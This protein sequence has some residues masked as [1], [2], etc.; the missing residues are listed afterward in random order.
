MA[1]SSFV[2]IVLLCSLIIPTKCYGHYSERS[3]DVA[4]SLFIFGDSFFD[5]GNNNY[6]NTSGQ[7]NYYPYGETFFNYPSGRFCDG[8]ILP[9]FIAEYA[10]LPFI[11]P[12][13]FPGNHDFKYGANFASGGAGA[14]NE[15]R[16]GFVINLKTQLGYLKKI[17]N[18]L[19]QQMGYT[20][21]K[22]LFSKAVYIFSV[23][24]NDYSYPFD[25]NPAVL[26]SHTTQQ[27]VGMVIGNITEV[28]QEIYNIGGRKVGF[29]SLGPI[30]CAPFARVLNK[31]GACFEKFT[32]FLKLHNKQ[33]SIAL[34]DLQSKLKGFKYSLVDV[35]S[36]MEERINHP[37]K[38]GFKEGKV[39]CCGSG[40]YRGNS[41]CGSKRG[42]KKYELCEN[43]KDYVFFDNGHPTEKLY[44]QLATEAWSGKPN[45]P[46]TYNLEALFQ[47]N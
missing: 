35:Y 6:I 25:T 21:A 9:D 32:P 22:T 37:S 27:Y 23:G 42:E 31:S 39:G 33:L 3:A 45:N 28:I 13:L 7:A 20:D 40:P 43:V 34:K 46:G 4:G 38:Y 10:N 11:P 14:L 15:T 18:Q 41:S 1:K 16:Q 26:N 29:L 36:F 5:A 8:R 30:G 44:N 19:K 47:S 2:L 12:Y 24:S 17:S